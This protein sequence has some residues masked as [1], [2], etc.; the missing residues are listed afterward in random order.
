MGLL[1]GAF[2]TEAP[3]LF[4]RGSVSFAFRSVLSSRSERVQRKRAFAHRGGTP[5]SVARRGAF[6]CRKK[7]GSFFRDIIVDAKDGRNERGFALF[8]R[9]RARG[10]AR[11][12]TRAV[13]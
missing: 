4:R 1:F 12:S 11:G 6:F 9:I 13:C 5:W 8:E 10:N 7:E 2:K 3:C